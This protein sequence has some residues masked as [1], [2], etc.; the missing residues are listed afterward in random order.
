MFVI[1]SAQQDALRD[2]ARA[3]FHRRILAFLR[4]T[5]PDRTKDMTDEELLRRISAADRRATNLGLR[6]ERGITQFVSLTL[7][8]RPDFDEIPRIQTYFAQPKPDQDTKIGWYVKVLTEYKRLAE[9]RG[10]VARI[11]DAG[12]R[13]LGLLLAALLPPFVMFATAA[14]GAVLTGEVA[15]TALATAGEAIA[16][17]LGAAA[18][19]ILTPEVLAAAVVVGAGLIVYNEMSNVNDESQDVPDEELDEDDTKDCPDPDENV[20][21]KKLSKG[22]IKKL[23]DAGIDP[24]DLKPNSKYDLFKDKDGNIIV[25]PKSGV[26]PGDPT[27]LNINNL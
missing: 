16:S 10:P 13:V 22:E 17:V 14:G 26:G 24:H 12:Q 15:T 5:L 23:K 6:T 18:A 27:G 25:K 11:R 9:D 1:R 8:I 2:A 21:D 3:P 7:M 4:K 20:Q 19:V